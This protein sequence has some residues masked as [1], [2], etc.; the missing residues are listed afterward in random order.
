M[1]LE[2]TP[3]PVPTIAMGFDPLTS[4]VTPLAMLMLVKSK[5]ATLPPVTETACP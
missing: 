1:P 5:A 4:K 2:I 3:L